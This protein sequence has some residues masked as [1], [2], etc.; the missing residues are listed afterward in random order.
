M[1]D[2]ANAVQDATYAGAISTKGP[3]PSA[4]MIFPT[5]DETKAMLD[6]KLA[7]VRDNFLL[8]YILEE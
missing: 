7:S 3:Q 6:A 8:I 1:D 2:L 4:K 5:A